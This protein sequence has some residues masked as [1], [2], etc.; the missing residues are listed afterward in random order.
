MTFG[1]ITLFDKSALQSLNL[2]EAVWFDNFYRT[3]ITPL[4]FLETLADLSKKM[5]EGRSPEQTVGSIAAKTPETG[6][7]VNVD[8]AETWPR[9]FERI[10]DRDGSQAQWVMV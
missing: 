8:D 3:I 5:G 10:S 1:P 7:V 6:S 4:F 2:D 9:G